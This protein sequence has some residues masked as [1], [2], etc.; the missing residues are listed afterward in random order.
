MT[1]VKIQGSPT[2]LPAIFDCNFPLQYI[3]VHLRN[4]LSNKDPHVKASQLHGGKTTL[5]WRLT[6]KAGYAKG[7]LNFVLKEAESYSSKALINDLSNLAKTYSLLPRI[8]GKVYFN[9]K[10]YLIYE[11]AYS[12]RKTTFE[13]TKQV[14][15]ETLKI[16]ADFHKSYSP[17]KPDEN[18]V[19]LIKSRGLEVFNKS[20]IEPFFPNAN[21]K[22]LELEKMLA[23]YF[24]SDRSFLALFQSLPVQLTNGDIKPDNI[25]ITE[26][27]PKLIDWGDSLF[28]KRIK[29]IAAFIVWNIP[30]FSNKNEIFNFIS[31]LPKLLTNNN[32]LLTDKEKQIF[33]SFLVLAIVDTDSWSFSVL[34]DKSPS[35]RNDI[36]QM[37]K[38]NWGFL[39]AL[40]SQDTNLPGWPPLVFPPEIQKAIAE[41]IG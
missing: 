23:N 32:I 18:Y 6:F 9:K 30:A 35:I 40:L 5:P 27:G 36:I 21:P 41:K 7:E 22:M 19:S 2:F 13:D 33:L 37:V 28:D 31:N 20:S 3:K 17:Q 10:T 1:N 14:L 12:A 34:K 26:K 16:T 38:H 25:I 39:R 4:I 29:E 11:Y 8:Y 15:L 24:I